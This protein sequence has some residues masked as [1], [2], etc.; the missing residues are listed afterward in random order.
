MIEKISNVDILNKDKFSTDYSSIIITINIEN[1]T[2]NNDTNLNYKIKYNI[3]N[4]NLSKETSPC[5]CTQT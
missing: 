2:N 4:Q 1:N 3:L 5:Q